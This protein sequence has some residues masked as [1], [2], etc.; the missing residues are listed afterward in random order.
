MQHTFI[1]ILR[2]AL[3]EELARDPAVHLLGED[4]AA[5]GA[6]GVTKGLAQKHGSMRVRNT[7]ISEAA[8]TGLATGAALCGL[9]PV[10]EIMFIDFATLAMD[11]LVN[12]TAKYRYMS[13]GQLAVPLVVRTQAGAA[14][15]GA[16]RHSQGPE[17]RFVY[18]PGPFVGPPPTPAAGDGLF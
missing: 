17:G 13:G 12:Q 15:G 14:G 9:K 10:L 7:P 1:E 16:A 11:C 2:R 18:L 8:I 5:G 3:D 6:F 4:V